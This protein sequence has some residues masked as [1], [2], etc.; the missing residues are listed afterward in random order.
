MDLEPVKKM[1]KTSASFMNVCPVGDMLRAPLG[2]LTLG[3]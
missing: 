2:L 3:G 1:D